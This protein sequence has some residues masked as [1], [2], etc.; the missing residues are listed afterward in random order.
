MNRP[1]SLAIIGS[2]FASFCLVANLLDKAPH[3]A[4]QI[5]C[6]GPPPF[7]AGAAYSARHRDFRLN[8]R[9]SI[10][11]I[12]PD[13]P[14]DFTRWAATHLDDEQAVSP[15]GAF[16]R[17]C[18]FARYLGVRLS[19]LPA[20]S[21]VAFIPDNVVA[22][23]R[24]TGSTDWQITT[25]AA[26][27]KAA[28]VVLATGNPP[29]RWPCAV[30]G[31]SCDD[32]LV[33]MPWHGQWAERIDSGQQV[34]LIGGGLTAMDAIYVLAQQQHQAKI[35]VIS[36]QP[37]LPPSQ[38]DWVPRKAIDWPEN[39]NTARTVFRFMRTVLRD[40][41]WDSAQWQSRFEALRVHINSVWQRL[42][43]SEKRRLMRHAGPAWQLAR[44]RSSP[45][46]A[47]AAEKLL[48]AG[49]LHVCKG[50]VRQIDTTGRQITL[51]L[52]NGHM[53]KADIVINCTGPSADPLARQLIDSGCADYDAFGRSVRLSPSLQVT[54]SNGRVYDNLWA[55]GAMTA[56][57]TG[58][59][60]GASTIARQMAGLAGQLAARLDGHS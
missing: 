50:R 21:D 3:L 57:S 55:G 33:R 43:D 54:H 51:V 34:T 46:S 22:L 42:S 47:D 9:P 20:I 58:D 60:V 12:W 6:F 41:D 29:P 59:V 11:Q 5:T 19:D 53:T 14:D 32:R 7:G 36:P 25:K 26:S 38:T 16:Y 1:V 48:S 30:S 35:T 44:F 10:M 2:G 24:E 18:D 4:G 8:V 17:R 13:R 28:N 37:C 15:Q 23:Q 49:Q 39:I 31:D 40:R 45:Q 56:G 27:Y 52:N